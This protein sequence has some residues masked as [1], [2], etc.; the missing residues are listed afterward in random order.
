[1]KTL[2]VATLF[3]GLLGGGCDPPPMEHCATVSREDAVIACEGADECTLYECRVD[4]R[5]DPSLPCEAG[6][7]SSACDDCRSRAAIETL[8]KH[9][10]ARCWCL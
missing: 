3:L 10:V 2:R 7:G 1:M 9:L 6:P 4:F 5:L 8:C